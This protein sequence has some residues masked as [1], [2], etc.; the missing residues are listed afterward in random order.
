MHLLVIVQNMCVLLCYQS[1]QTYK[2]NIL[3]AR[4]IYINVDDDDD[5]DDNNN[6]SKNNNES[7]CWKLLEPEMKMCLYL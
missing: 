6:N 4:C 1:S 7:Y 2:I 3:Y 5:D